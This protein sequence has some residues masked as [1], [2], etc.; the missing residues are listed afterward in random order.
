MNCFDM[1]VNEWC[2]LENVRMLQKGPES[3]GKAGEENQVP[4]S[5][6]WRSN[7]SIRRA[8]SFPEQ[9]LCP[10]DNGEQTPIGPS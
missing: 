8:S 1:R 3:E 2:S 9:L 6:L 7:H 5:W 10:S 4:S